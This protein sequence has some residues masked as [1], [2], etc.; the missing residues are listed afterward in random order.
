MQGGTAEN[1][2]WLC[3]LDR[4][5]CRAKLPCAVQHMPYTR[6]QLDDLYDAAEVESGQAG[7]YPFAVCPPAAKVLASGE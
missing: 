3:R 7:S 2:I 5:N 4:V 6:I 1:C